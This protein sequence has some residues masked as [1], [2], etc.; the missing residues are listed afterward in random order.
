MKILSM[1]IENFRSIKQ[2][3]INFNDFTAIVGENDAGKTAILRALN[4]VFHFNDELPYFNNN[5][6]QY[7]PKT[8]TKIAIT[9]GDV[10]SNSIYKNAETM[11]LV[12]KYNY[13]NSKRGKSISVIVN[14]TEN[15][16]KDDFLIKLKEDIDFVYIPSNRSVQDLKCESETILY[17]V[18][19]AYLQK[20]TKKRDQLSSQTKRAAE[21]L[22]RNGL[23]RIDN[24]LASLKLLSQA[25]KYEFDYAEKIDYTIF[26]S[27]VGIKVDDGKILPVSE[28]GSGINSLTVIAL[29]RLWAMITKKS[30]ILGIEE[31]ETN[32]H[33]QAQKKFIAMLKE[34]RL[35]SEVQAIF[36]THSPSIVDSLEHEDVVLVR[37]EKNRSRGFNS[38]ISQL[39]R[40]FWV[41]CGISSDKKD[42]FFKFK[43][44]E[45]FFSKY[46]ILV[47]GPCDAKVIE[48]MLKNELGLDMCDVCILNLD[49]VANLKYPL[50]LLKKLALPYAAIVDK[51][52]LFTYKNENVTS[53]RDTNGFPEY[54]TTVQKK[55]IRIIQEVYQVPTI[56]V[57]LQK[58]SRESYSKLF[59]Y[60]L[61]YDIYPMCYCL[62]IDLMSVEKARQKAYDYLNLNVSERNS[63]TV[64]CKRKK[65]IKD[66]QF[67]L[68]VLSQLQVRE[69][70]ISY[71]KIKKTLVNNIKNYLH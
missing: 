17:R 33:P 62:E 42:F 11:Q 59:N 21:T 34:K 36:A 71:K 57:D 2:A 7:M 70:P 66:S 10:P 26:L 68:T 60:M 24:E 39:P 19:L 51:D 49:G 27:K 35:I 18:I 63:Q 43:N 64:L 40:D 65:D 67:L 50:L 9:F 15:A 30:I 38:L 3:E 58:L 56:G 16:V 55:Y 12:F 32:L 6:H 25:T 41:T 37:K 4:A 29:Y 53:S 69:Y 13:S 48:Y 22:K 44:S 20:Y 54:S 8:I 45:F 46:V 28:H 47:E 31:P 61:Q 52:F 23:A 1:R 14:D 5:N